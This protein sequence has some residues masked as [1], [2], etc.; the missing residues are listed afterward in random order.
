MPAPDSQL[1]DT[2]LGA[3]GVAALRIDD[4]GAIVGI[5]N[6][7]QLREWVAPEDRAPRAGDELG[8]TLALLF[9]AGEAGRIVAACNSRFASGGTAAD[10]FTAVPSRLRLQT[11]QPR[12]FDVALRGLPD[13]PGPQLLLAL[14]EVT[15]MKALAAAL[16]QA[17]AAHDLALTVLCTDTGTLRTFL[18]RAA[19]GVATIR[20]TLRQ[21]ARTQPALQEKLRRL[22]E[23]ALA[24]RAAAEA[25]PLLAVAAPLAALAERL[26]ELRARAEPS[27]DDL[28]PLA[29]HIDAISTTVAAVLSLDERRALRR[30]R[31]AA[32]R[33]PLLAMAGLARDLRAEL[34]GDSCVA[35]RSSMVVSRSCACKGIGAGARALS[36]RDRAGAATAAAQC[37]S[38]WHRDRPSSG[39]PPASRPPAASPSRS[40][41]VARTASR[42]TVHDDG[43]GFDLERIRA[44]ASHCG[45][46]SDAELAAIDPRQLVGFV[47]KRSF[48]TAGLEET[49]PEDQGVAHLR[50]TLAREGGTVS[51]ATKA[52]RYTMFT[53]RLPAPAAANPATAI[54]PGPRH[55]LP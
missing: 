38:A 16:E 55:A 42:V 20:S 40:A 46:G 28:L 13:S 31:C 50:Q 45:I 11:L 3:V 41:T 17:R 7:A 36:P 49:P 2:L 26:A 1:I 54:D 33:A 37:G 35:A 19:G 6:D 8:P 23:E 14:T 18:R 27:G 30:R 39:S 51:V 15:A 47:F 12:Y 53:I 29:L 21:P 22:L 52:Q 24:L 32:R 25:V 43:R 48:S 5:H 44:A 10:S 4:T 9:D 34:R